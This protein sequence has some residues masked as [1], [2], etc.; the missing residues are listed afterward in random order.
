MLADDKCEESDTAVVTVPPDDATL[1]FRSSKCG[2]SVPASGG[3][4]GD[5]NSLISASM[6]FGLISCGDS[7]PCWA[8]SVRV[9]VRSTRVSRPS[10]AERRRRVRRAGF[11][12]EDGGQR[13]GE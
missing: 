12:F 1:L 9:F 3:V 5:V 10:V 13:V 2:S 6:S 7:L 4:G 8:I 11:D